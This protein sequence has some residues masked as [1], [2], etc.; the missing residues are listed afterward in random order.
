MAQTVATHSYLKD[1]IGL[2][3]NQAVTGC[4]NSIISE[5][6]DDPSNLVELR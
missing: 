1:V 4:A 5:G 3:A 6:L 2:G